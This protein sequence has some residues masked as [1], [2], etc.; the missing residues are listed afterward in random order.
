MTNLA[1]AFF[2]TYKKFFVYCCITSHR[3]FSIC[4]KLFSSIWSLFLLLFSVYT[5]LIEIEVKDFTSDEC[6]E[7]KGPD[8]KHVAQK[9]DI[10]LML[11][12]LR[13]GLEKKKFL[14][15]EKFVSFTTQVCHLLQKEF[16]QQASH[17]VLLQN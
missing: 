8:L 12:Q 11:D 3:Y 15:M 5:I 1:V 2:L 7:S 9:V 10:R 4:T 16:V 14:S 6:Q 17:S 13:L